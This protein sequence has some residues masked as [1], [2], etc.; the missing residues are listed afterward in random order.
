MSLAWGKNIS[1]FRPPDT[2]PLPPRITAYGRNSLSY[3]P[4]E[5]IKRD[6]RRGLML[7]V[8]WQAAADYHLAKNKIRAKRVRSEGDYKKLK[9]WDRETIDEGKLAWEWFTGESVPTSKTSYSYKDICD[10]F[11]VDPVK[12]WRKIKKT[13][14]LVERL[15]QMKQ[16]E[17]AML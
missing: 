5:Y 13:P 8:L 2:Q 17:G 15:G 3:F 9:R 6:S 14:D 1:Y 7:A 11:K 16:A 12:L 10:Y 4:Q